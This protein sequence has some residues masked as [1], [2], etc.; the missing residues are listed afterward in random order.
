MFEC[1]SFKMK[2]VCGVMGCM[3]FGGCE[4]SGFDVGEF[5]MYF[6]EVYDMVCV[7]EGGRGGYI[8]EVGEVVD[9]VVC[10]GE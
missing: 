7:S 6:S 3:K 2:S 10:G 9:G 4:L 8:D 5:V 1:E